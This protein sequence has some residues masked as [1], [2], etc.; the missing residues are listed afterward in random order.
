MRRDLAVGQIHHQR[1]QNARLVAIYTIIEVHEGTAI[2]TKTDVKGKI[3]PGRFM[4]PDNPLCR[5]AS[6]PTKQEDKH[7]G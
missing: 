1:D 7:A 4:L 6:G 2:C 5:R 3:I